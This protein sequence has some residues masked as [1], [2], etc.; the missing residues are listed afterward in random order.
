MVA[1]KSWM[2]SIIGSSSHRCF[3]TLDCHVGYPGRVHFGWFYKRTTIGDERGGGLAACALGIWRP[4]FRDHVFFSY[5]SFPIFPFWRHIVIFG[6]LCSTY[7]WSPETEMREN[8]MALALKTPYQLPSQNDVWSFWLPSHE[9]KLCKI[10]D[11]RAS[12][13]NLRNDLLVHPLNLH[14]A[15]QLTTQP[16]QTSRAKRKVVQV[17]A[18]DL[19]LFSFMWVEPGRFPQGRA[20]LERSQGVEH[21]GGFLM[22]SQNCFID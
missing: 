7:F 19:E 4:Q 13:K 15:C 6:L 2:W 5:N 17:T 3:D 21:I 10:V 8:T 12:T 14:L 11:N 1:K 9:R 22:K 16:A 18:W 20:K